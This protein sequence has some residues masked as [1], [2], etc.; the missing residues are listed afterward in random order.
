M[1]AGKDSIM[2]PRDSIKKQSIKGEIDEL[3]VLYTRLLETTH[4]NALS[5]HSMKEQEQE[6]KRQL[7]SLW[8]SVED[9]KC[10]SVELKKSLDTEK[11]N[12]ALDKTMD[13]QLQGL[14][15]VVSNIAHLERS[16]VAMARALDATRHDMDLRGILPVDEGQLTEKLA[17]CE[18]VLG[19]VM[20][21]IRPKL[22]NVTSFAESTDAVVTTV[23]KELEQL[24]RCWSSLETVTKQQVHHASVY[25]ECKQRTT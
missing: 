4:L 7:Y 23:D 12:L 9:K 3:E 25:L 19:D 24:K 20:M 21:D 18:D 16:Y 22:S 14:G 1:G 8:K 11:R 5:A 15:P 10:N 17:E 13:I 6:A 2:A